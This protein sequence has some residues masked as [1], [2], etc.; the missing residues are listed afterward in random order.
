M[1]TPDKSPFPGR[2]NLASLRV[3]GLGQE[4]IFALTLVLSNHSRETVDQLVWTD[5]LDV[6]SNSLSP[7][8]PQTCWGRDQKMQ[9]PSLSIPR[10]AS[11][12]HSIII[13]TP[14]NVIIVPRSCL[15]LFLVI[16]F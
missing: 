3:W 6:L 11:S 8:M 15:G 7:G 5:S 16:V 1:R 2:F 9:T 12:P 13:I 10:K 4:L 14:P